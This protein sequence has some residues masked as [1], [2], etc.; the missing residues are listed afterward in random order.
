MTEED[1]WVTMEDITVILFFDTVGSINLAYL[2]DDNLLFFFQESIVNPKKLIFLLFYKENRLL[3]KNVQKNICYSF[4]SIIT[5]AVD[6]LI[7]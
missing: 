6:L 5:I 7:I 3:L 1:D 4:T 2:S